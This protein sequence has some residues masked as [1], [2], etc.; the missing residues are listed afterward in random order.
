MTSKAKLEELYAD[1]Q[2]R[3]KKRL[4]ELEAQLEVATEDEKKVLTQKIHSTK[5]RLGRTLGGMIR[6]RGNLRTGRRLKMCF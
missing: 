5:A 4:G 6:S 3:D 2:R 1:G